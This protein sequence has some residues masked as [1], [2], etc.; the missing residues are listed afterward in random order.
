MP[1]AV[2]SL[3]MLGVELTSL[4]ILVMKLFH[5]GYSGSG[6]SVLTFHLIEACIGGT[7]LLCTFRPP[8]ALSALKME[9]YLEQDHFI[10][11][12]RVYFGVAF[13]CLID[14]TFIV[15]LPWKE[16]KFATLS[17]GFPNI[18][19]FRVVQVGLILTAVISFCIQVSFLASTTFSVNRDLMFVLNIILLC[20]KVTLI[21]LE[22]GYKNTKLREAL[23]AIDKVDEK[24]GDVELGSVHPENED[25]IVYQ[26]NP[27]IQQ[28][29]SED[30][31]PLLRRVDNVEHETKSVKAKT[32]RM[33]ENFNLAIK[34]MNEKM[35]K[36][37]NSS[38]VL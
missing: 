11:E 29:P 14:L 3:G 24:G 21:M 13:L 7:L 19:V 23:T 20:I 37:A 32:E 8:K 16:S 30:T 5:Y 25:D 1:Y 34:E 6:V 15:F 36:L 22:F 18:L 2:A 28:S 33:E 4:V 27:M 10:S 12:S 17:K 26:H 35:E 9:R 38:K 31:V